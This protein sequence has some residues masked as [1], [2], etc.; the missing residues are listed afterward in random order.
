MKKRNWYF[1]F[2]GIVAALL[3]IFAMCVVFLLYVIVASCREAGATISGTVIDNTNLEIVTTAISLGLLFA[4]VLAIMTSIKGFTKRKV[5]LAFIIIQIAVYVAISVFLIINA[6]GG[7]EIIGGIIIV[8]LYVII[9]AVYVL[10]LIKQIKDSKAE[11][12]NATAEENVTAPSVE[13]GSETGD[14]SE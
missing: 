11:N 7:D 13:T 10:G 12:I 1:A 6:F 14:V 2:G 5:P 8:A 4:V 9:T 3:D